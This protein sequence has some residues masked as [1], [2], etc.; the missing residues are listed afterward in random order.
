MENT[1]TIPSM[2]TLTTRSPSSSRLLPMICTP[3]FT[4][5]CCP[6]RTILVPARQSQHTSALSAPAETRFFDDSATAR[7]PFR[8]PAS[9]WSG[10]KV[11]EEKR[12]T[13]LENNVSI[14]ELCYV[15]MPL[16]QRR[17][18]QPRKPLQPIE[19]RQQGHRCR[20]QQSDAPSS[21]RKSTQLTGFLT[22]R[23]FFI[24]PVSTSQN[25]IVSS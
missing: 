3:M 7:M 5:V 9:C 20:A 2:V 1:R 17:G 14:D 24:S 21:A 11:R 12:C 15:D 23:H 18:S 8:W 13:R 19:S 25:R 10:V 6:N 22:C 4:V 16:T